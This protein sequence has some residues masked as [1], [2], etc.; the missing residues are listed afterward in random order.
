MKIVG[1]IFDGLR[2]VDAKYDLSFSWPN[3]Y[4]FGQSK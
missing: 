3:S 2:A 1:N 4:I